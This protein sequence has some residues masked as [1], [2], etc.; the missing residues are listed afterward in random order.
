MLVE[1]RNQQGSILLATNRHANRRDPTVGVYVFQFAAKWTCYC[2]R[3]HDTTLQLLLTSG[4]DSRSL[5]R[6]SQMVNLCG[7][8]RRSSYKYCPYPNT[9]FSSVRLCHD[10]HSIFHR[11]PF[12]LFQKPFWKHVP[13][14]SRLSTQIGC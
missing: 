7:S 12:V 8:A 13:I 14:V 4:L 10:L 9:L 2:R 6:L 5:K 11:M 1:R 3:R